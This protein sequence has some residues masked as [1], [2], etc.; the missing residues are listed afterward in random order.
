V[1]FVSRLDADRL[2][3]NFLVH[4]DPDRQEALGLALTAAG[5]AKPVAPKRGQ[6]FEL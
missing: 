5:Y 2:K 1:D 3:R 4:G 6:S